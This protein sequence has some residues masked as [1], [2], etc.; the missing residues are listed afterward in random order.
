M[1]AETVVL[2]YFGISFGIALGFAFQMGRTGDDD[3]A[4]GIPIAFLWP[5]FALALILVG[6]FY[7]IH[8][9][10]KCFR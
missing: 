5:G 2:I 4:A 3:L 10:G 1:S 7:L 6:P 9:L 8:R